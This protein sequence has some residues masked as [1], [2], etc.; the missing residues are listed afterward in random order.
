MG[1]NP[2]VPQ[3]FDCITT[4]L[5]KNQRMILLRKIRALDIFVLLTSDK[6]QY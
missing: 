6:R 2:K 5:H 3:S 4:E 1:T